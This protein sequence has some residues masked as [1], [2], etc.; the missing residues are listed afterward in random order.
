M[1]DIIILGKHARIMNKLRT[2]NLYD[3]YASIYENACLVGLLYGK[4]S[5][6]FKEKKYKKEEDEA[7]VTRTY[8]QRRPD[9][10]RILLTMLQQEKFFEGEP[11][12][13]NQIFNTE[14]LD[15]KET[16]ELHDELKK[17]AL[18]GLEIMGDEYSEI[19][20]T[21]EQDAIIQFQNDRSL[22]NI[23][24]IDCY[25][26]HFKQKKV[27]KIDSEIAELLSDFN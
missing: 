12:V 11:L 24:E 6:Q 8:F 20:N 1:I 2:L 21:L 17:Y 22:K 26:E 19:E 9:H 10:E 7:Q 13:V 23:K 27:K 15:D 16:N 25:M 4:K 5:E 3:N 14:G 18:Y